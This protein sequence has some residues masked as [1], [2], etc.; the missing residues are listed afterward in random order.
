MSQHQL[1]V[2]AAG[3]S[4]KV[5]WAEDHKGSN[6]SAGPRKTKT[7]YLEPQFKESLAFK[8]SQI[9]IWHLPHLRPGAV[10][11]GNLMSEDGRNFKLT[12]ITFPVNMKIISFWNWWNLGQHSSGM[13][14]LHFSAGYR[15]GWTLMK[16]VT[17]YYC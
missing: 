7:R 14:P 8:V 17:C 4:A 11:H 3:M 10:K 6:S 13:F 5:V 1:I 9:Q 15:E 12:G 16:G 2:P